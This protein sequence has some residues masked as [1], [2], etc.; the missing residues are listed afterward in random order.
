MLRSTRAVLLIFSVLGIVVTSN[1]YCDSPTEELPWI[2][3]AEQGLVFFVMHPSPSDSKID[4][5]GNGVCYRLA[6]DGTL[7]EL[8]RVSGWY[9][10]KGYLSDSGEVL[11]RLGPWATDLEH[12]TDL[13]VAFYKNG[14]LVKKYRVNELVKNK[15]KLRYSSS[16]YSWLA[17]RSNFPNGFHGDEFILTLIDKTRYSFDINTGEITGTP[18][19]PFAAGRAEIDSERENVLGTET[20]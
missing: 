8:W 3:P 10:S 9:C 15:Q 7:K 19:D 16:H 20:K 2:L 4:H 6:G 18:S 1:G 17:A 12:H 13:A 5:P 11:V 14:K